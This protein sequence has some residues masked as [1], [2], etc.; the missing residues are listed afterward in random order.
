[1]KD[2]IKMGRFDLPQPLLHMILVKQ[3]RSGTQAGLY[4]YGGLKRLTKSPSHAASSKPHGD[5]LIETIREFNGASDTFYERI[6]DSYN[7]I[8]E[9]NKEFMNWRYCD[10]RG[11]RF[12]IKQAKRGDDVLGYIILEVKT[13]G[14]NSEGYIIDMLAEDDEVATS[15]LKDGINSLA[16]LGVGTFNYRVVKNHPYQKI[17]EKLGFVAPPNVI[18]MHV[19][20]QFDN[21][22]EAKETLLATEPGSI[23][24]NYGDYF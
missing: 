17:S 7:F 11:G 13:K 20:C 21:A 18:D 24:F 16:V 23:H 10:I 19:Y 5:Y 15:L 1:M 4:L 9:R 22:E 2:N 6:K 8:V 12:L 14:E 3:A